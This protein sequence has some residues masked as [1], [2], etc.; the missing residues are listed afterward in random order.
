[1]AR[2]TYKAIS[3]WIQ[4]NDWISHERDQNLPSFPVTWLSI[5]HSRPTAEHFETWNIIL[6]PSM[7]SG[8]E[9]MVDSLER[10]RLFG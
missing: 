8:K 6:G 5:E 2:N 1:M 7:D 4:I 9:L 10:Q 3:T